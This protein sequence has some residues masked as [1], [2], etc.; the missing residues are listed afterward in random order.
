MRGYTKSEIVKI[1]AEHGL[2]LNES[3]TGPGPVWPLLELMM[4]QESVVI[5]KLDGERNPD[6]ANGNFTVIAMGGGLQEREIRGDFEDLDEALCYL[7]GNY[8][9]V[10]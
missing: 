3:W 5:L 7:I 10:E 6:V 9:R 8:F 1:A 2:T 4:S